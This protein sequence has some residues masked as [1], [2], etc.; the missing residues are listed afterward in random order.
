MGVTDEGTR[1]TLRLPEQLR[2][3]LHQSANDNHR[4]L[5][6]EIVT[7]L[8]SRKVTDAGSKKALIKELSTRCQ[9]LSED[10][11]QVLVDLSQRMHS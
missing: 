2:D 4:S 11:I 7:I 9:K 10:S 6:S 8:S 1:F 5:N 3:L